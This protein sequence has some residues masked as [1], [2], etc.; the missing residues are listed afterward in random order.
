L[1][2]LGARY[3]YEEKAMRAGYP[4]VAGVDEAGRGPLAGP[5]VAA[6][7]VIRD[8]DF[9]AEIDDSKRLSPK[10]R[11]KAYSEIMEKCSVGVGTAT[12]EEIDRLNIYNATLVAMKRAVEALKERPDHLLIDGT[13]KV[14]LPIGKTCLTSGE[15]KS[16][17]IACA[18]IVAK[19]TRDRMM[20]DEDT[21]YPEYGFLKH[22]GYGTREHIKAIGVHGLSPIHRRSFGPFGGKHAAGVDTIYSGLKKGAAYE[23]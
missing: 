1:K 17:S 13:M 7:A 14:D 18:S 11:E 22:K 19:V 5:V 9:T 3:S 23:R 20:I 4:V 8:L 12:V 21:R 15:T 16:I 10:K 6:A 2:D